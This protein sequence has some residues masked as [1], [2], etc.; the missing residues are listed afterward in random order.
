MSK[1]GTLLETRP[2]AKGGQVPESTIA[3]LARLDP[4]G[5]RSG[6]R[7]VPGVPGTGL[8]ALATPRPGAARSGPWPLVGYC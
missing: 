4:H 6:H 7:N 3:I 1:D 5:C 2:A 8:S